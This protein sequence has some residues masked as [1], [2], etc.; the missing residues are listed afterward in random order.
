MSYITIIVIL[1]LLI[2]GYA[3]SKKENLSSFDN[4]DIELNPIT[5]KEKLQQV[6]NCNLLNDR[7]VCSNTKG[8]TFDEKTLGCY[9]DWPNV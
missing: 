2:F 7:D 3:I 4:K 6:P 9:Y 5:R 8:C 1:I